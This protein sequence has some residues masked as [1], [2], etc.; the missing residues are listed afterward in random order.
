MNYFGE[1]LKMFLSRNH[2]TNTELGKR[3]GV[4]EVTVSRWV[5]GDRNP[6]AVMVAKIC[7]VFGCTYDDLMLPNSEEIQRD[8]EAYAEVLQLLEKLNTSGIEEVINFIGLLDS[9]YIK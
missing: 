2:M 5:S 8:K 6:R 7:E 3:I 1:N 9:R 4:S